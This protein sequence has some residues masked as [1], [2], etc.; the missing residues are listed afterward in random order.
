MSGNE[1]RALGSK[2]RLESRIGRGGMGEVWRGRDNAGNPLA[3]KLLLPQFA[4]DR[5]VVSRFIA[6]RHLLTSVRHPHVVEF[7]DLVIEGATLA[8]VMELVNGSDLRQYIRQQ[9]TLAPAEACRLG[10]QLARG[11]EALHTARIMHRDVKPE[12]TLLDLSGPQPRVKLTDFGVARLA[13]DGPGGTQH[14][15][16]A[17]TPRYMAPELL[18]GQLP[19]PQTDLYSFGIV[20]YEMLGGVTPFAGMSTAAMVGAHLNFNPGY[21]PGLDDRLW[22]LI[23]QLMEKDP[24]GRPADA[25]M[26][27]GYLEHLAPQLRGMPGLPPQQHAPDPVPVAETETRIR[28]VADAGPRPGVPGPQG[29]LFGPGDTRQL[30]QPP[31]PPPGHAAMYPPGPPMA[32]APGRPPVGPMGAPPAPRKRRAPLVIGIVAGLVLVL[33]GLGAFLF[34]TRPWSGDDVV[35][36]PMHSPAETPT[37]TAEPTPT[38]AAETT[39]AEQPTREAPPPTTTQPAPPTTSAPPPAPA[40]P[41]AGTTTCSDY[42]AVNEVTSCSFAFNV[43]NSYYE[44]GE[45]RVVEAWSPV[46]EQWYE[47]TCEVQQASIIRCT[48]GNNA[49]LYFRQ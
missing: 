12:N 11:L 9:G 49:V 33:G 38:E 19:T 25:G 2:Y 18:H 4:E 36:T 32:P 17:G 5:E 26:V 30:P 41:P 44:Q 42:V 45:P 39:P 23:L 43:V 15:A 34:L 16:L 40:W 20:L 13:E 14:T 48:G 28:P 21:L 1:A 29:A 3:F 47:M 24:A 7:H 37:P 6:E 31:G 10:A 8:I 22:Q 46:T 35:A 27:A